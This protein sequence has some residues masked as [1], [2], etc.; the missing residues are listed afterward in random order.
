MFIKSDLTEEQRI[1]KTIKQLK[2]KNVKEKFEAFTPEIV[3]RLNEVL[4]LDKLKDDELKKL[5]E[6]TLKDFHNDSSVT[7]NEKVLK[8]LIVCDEDLSVLI[9]DMR[10]TV[11][12]STYDDR[13]RNIIKFIRNFDHIRYESYVVLYDDKKT[14]L[15]NQL[16]SISKGLKYKASKSSHRIKQTSAEIE[17]L[18]NENVDFVT[19][20]NDVDKRSFKYQEI[21][22][23]VMDNHQNIENLKG[24]I[25]LMRKNMNAI[26]LIATLFDQLI[27]HEEYLKS[28]KEN[29]S[30]RKFIKKLYNKPEEMDSMET[31]LDLAE[32]LNSIRLEIEEMERL[33][34]PTQKMVL[35]NDTSNIDDDIIKQYQ[36]KK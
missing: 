4:A 23:Q 31:T 28:I 12:L 35:S 27:I 16:S 29:G 25:S 14:V 26:N 36:I 32:V 6:K 19:K 15:E 3:S 11:N 2:G 21:S 9:D 24:S 1:K 7:S 10:R 30:I 18:E 33:I 13:L 22:S 34:K 5:T 20:L 17:H 8:D